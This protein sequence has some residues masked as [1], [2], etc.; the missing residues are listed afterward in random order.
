MNA[1]RLV[2]WLVVAVLALGALLA[3]IFEAWP[4]LHPEIVTRASPDPGCDLRLGECVTRFPGMGRIS[5]SIWPHEI[6]LVQPLRLEVV[7]DDLTASG[8]EVDFSG[9]DMNM[10][11]NRAQLKPQAEGRFTGSAVLPVC[12]RDRMQW[13]AL[14]MVH[15]KGGIL[16]AP[17]RFWTARPGVARPRRGHE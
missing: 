7:V 14:V 3:V 10:G 9:V 17:Y 15:T 16:A 12:V 1:Q 5:L 8:V 11:F 6:P 4:L 2:L 13:E